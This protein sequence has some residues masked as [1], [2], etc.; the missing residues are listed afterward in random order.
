[1]QNRWLQEATDV[2]YDEFLSIPLFW[3]PVH[4]VANPEVVD[5]WVF[6]GTVSGAYTHM[7]D[8]IGTR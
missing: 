1:V 3:V 8:I 2:I 4:V 5:D 6:P 7:W